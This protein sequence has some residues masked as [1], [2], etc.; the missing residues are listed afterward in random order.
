MR[1]HD[2]AGQVEEGGKGGEM[3]STYLVVKDPA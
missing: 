3:P 1:I 2:L